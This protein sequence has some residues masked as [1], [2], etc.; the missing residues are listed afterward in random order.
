MLYRHLFIT[1]FALVYSISSIAIAVDNQ[2]LQPGNYLINLDYLGGDKLDKTSADD[3]QEPPHTAN[4][5]KNYTSNDHPS[6]I[7]PD[8]SILRIVR[9]PKLSRAPPL[10]A[11][12]DTVTWPA[13]I[14]N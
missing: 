9:Y 5:V 6:T 10:I 3:T 11:N 2:P 1:L 4:A 13:S 14:T 12:R 7:T 8:H